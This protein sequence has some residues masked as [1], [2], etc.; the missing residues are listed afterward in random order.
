[1]SLIKLNN[2]I[3]QKYKLLSN[4]LEFE[5]TTTTNN[6]SYTVPHISGYVYNYVLDPGNGLGFKNITSYNDS[7]L[8]NIYSTPGKYI[9]KI[10]GK[11]GSLYSYNSTLITKIL[12]WGKVGLQSIIFYKNTNLTSFPD[13]KYGGLRLVTN[14]N[15]LF[16]QCPLT[17]IGLI[18]RFMS[19]VTSFYKTFAG[20]PAYIYQDICNI[21]EDLFKYNTNAISF[22]STFINRWFNNFTLP[23]NLFR[24]NT[25]VTSFNST[26]YFCISYI[27]PTD[28]F[29]Y[30]TEVT[31]FRQCFGESWLTGILRPPAGLFK[32]NTKCLDFYGVFEYSNCV[33]NLY[34]FCDLGQESTRFLNQN[35]DFRRFNFDGRYMSGYLPELWNYNYGTGTPITTNCFTNCNGASNFGSVPFE[36][37]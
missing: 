32:Y 15:S 4:S 14:V 28:M 25:N 7:G 9:I 36:W 11:C 33:D 26:F 27:I 19:G 16:E 8:T 34:I 21:P 3:I 23:V 30:N 24:Y 13:D 10:S 6:Q 22:N 18:F 2:S 31:T 37:K 17:S 35:I 12:N 1:M 5:I 29:K 20:N